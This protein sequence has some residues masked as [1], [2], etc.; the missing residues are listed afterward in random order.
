MATQ[1]AA[2]QMLRVFTVRYLNY[3]N[4]AE[5]SRNTIILVSTQINEENKL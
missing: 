5:D 3:S 2:K 1:F 4:I